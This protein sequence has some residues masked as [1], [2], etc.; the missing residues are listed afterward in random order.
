MKNYLRSGEVLQ[1]FKWHLKI[2]KVPQDRQKEEDGRMRKVCEICSNLNI[3]LD[4]TM[5]LFE[6]RC[7]HVNHTWCSWLLLYA[8]GVYGEDVPI[9]VCGICCL[10]K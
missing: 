5:T 10:L 1:M 6:R 4:K 3:M 9:G 2:N 7:G 8:L